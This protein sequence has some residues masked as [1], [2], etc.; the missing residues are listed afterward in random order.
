[1][2]PGRSAWSGKRCHA[3]TDVITVRTHPARQHPG[4]RERCTVLY[5]V[6]R[7]EDRYRPIPRPLCGRPT[8]SG[9]LVEGV[10]DFPPNICSSAH[11]W[12]ASRP[13]PGKAQSDLDPPAGAREA[14]TNNRPRRAIR[15]IGRAIE[16]GPC[17]AIYQIFRTR[18]DTL[19][20]GVRILMLDAAPIRGSTTRQMI[21]TGRSHA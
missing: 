3:G 5:W 8:T 21:C 2:V 13:P 20:A 1:M 10:A 18:D 4:I 16:L 17:C 19:L 6:L 7:L 15:Y 12:P 11:G 9:W 14:P